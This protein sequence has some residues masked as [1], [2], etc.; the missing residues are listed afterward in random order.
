MKVENRFNKHYGKA[1]IIKFKVLLVNTHLVLLEHMLTFGG[2]ER[3][4]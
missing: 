2:K 3:K 1:S 4:K